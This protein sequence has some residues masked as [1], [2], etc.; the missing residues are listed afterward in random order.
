M[1][2]PQLTAVIDT[3]NHERFI[4]KAVV[5]VLEQ[6][7]SPEEIEIIVV[8]DGSTDRTP[9]IVKKFEPRVQFVRK[10]N[11]GQ[12]TAFNAAMRESSGEIVAFLDG[13]DW[14]AR[15]KVRVVLDAFSKHPMIAAVGHGYFEV[16]EDSV[17]TAAVS[18]ERAL[19]LDLSSPEAAR[20]ADLGRMLLG[21]SRL[22][23]RRR[24][25]H[26]VG[27][28]PSELVFCA[29]TPIYSLAL[30]LG[31]ALILNEPLCYYRVHA[32]GLSSR[33]PDNLAK[34]QRNFELLG[35]LHTLL[36]RR[37]A[38][39]GVSE[40]IIAALFESERVEMER[41]ELQR[42]GGGRLRAFK[43]ETRAF[44]SSYKDSSAGYKVFKG[45]IG[46]LALVL[47]PQRFYD[48][49]HWYSR[50]SSMHRIRNLMG[51]GQPTVPDSLFQRRRV[52]GEQK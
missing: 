6:D 19:I 46:L 35:F 27:P 10:A 18:P 29:D 43:A 12:A 7:L 36:A 44:Q 13:D 38:E 17:T 26:Q 47:P 49:R 4:E 3:Y 52:T 41:F 39:L 30:A 20:V 11:G 21:T 16:N 33:G 1:P 25:M 22:A 9:D 37:L 8:D 32:G 28:L 51:R 31:G 50:Q 15:S 24:V 5:S 34:Q 40:Q 14:W 45:L 48:L 42:G 23:V 2:R